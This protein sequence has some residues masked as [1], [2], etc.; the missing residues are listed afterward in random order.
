[1][2]IQF[3]DPVPAVLEEAK[4]ITGKDIEFIPRDNMSTYAIFKMAR[5]KT[6]PP[7]LIY[8]RKDH[9]DIINHL[10]VHECGHLF[11]DFPLP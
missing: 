11:Q 3:I 5:K 2:D 9:D 8:Y 4:R 10:I 6:C 1:M 7:H